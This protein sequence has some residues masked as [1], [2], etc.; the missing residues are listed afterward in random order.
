MNSIVNI[1]LFVSVMSTF[2]QKSI[3]N[4]P[5][6][7]PDIEMNYNHMGAR[8]W[9]GRK[10]KDIIPPAEIDRII[11][12]KQVSV[13][14]K[15]GILIQS[16]YRDLISHLLASDGEANDWGLRATE[17][18]GPTLI[19]T[20][21]N[22]QIYYLEIIREMVGGISALTINGPGKGARFEL[23]GYQVKSSQK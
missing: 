15:N 23:D 16:D 2:S 4:N 12:L 14:L 18:T 10:F 7:F 9:G 8:D 1:L 13:G 20:T 6:G 11:V 5:S 17:S 3:S 22:G 21:K 19:I